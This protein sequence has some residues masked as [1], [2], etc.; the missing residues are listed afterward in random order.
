[1]KAIVF[2]RYGSTD[3]L[4]LQDIDTPRLEDGDV[5]VQVRAAAINPYDWHLMTGVPSFMRLQSG[6]R[7][8][9]INGIGSDLAGRVE[10]VGP[11]VTLFRPD[12][13]VYGRVDQLPGSNLMALGSVAEYVRV[14]EASIR[15]RPTR[16]TAEEAAAVPLAATTALWGMRDVGAVQA[17]QHV[18]V[19]GASGGVG[20]FAVQIAK[21]MGAQVTGV[22]STRNVALV[23]S[24]GADHIVDY[25]GED[26]TGGGPRFDLMLDNVG[27]HSPT[28]CLRILKPGGTYLASFD[29][30]WNRWLGPMRHVL[31][32]AMRS[33]FSG[34]RMV[35]LRP[36]R[37]DGDLDTLTELIDA[38]AVTPVVDRAFPLVDTGEA[39]E[40]LAGRHAR[41]KVIIIP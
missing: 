5:L 29:H 30:P 8:P 17:G 41:G 21:A 11:R 38:H 12:D 22:C 15:P 31:R 20:T 36:E 37:R 10:A 18:L 28:A 19:N 27:N 7:R 2:N 39:M 14:S 34:R 1:M 6:L 16:L 25:T 13:E 9:K 26:V 4:E 23:R 35:L 24:L 40:Y 33:R 3:V 32:M